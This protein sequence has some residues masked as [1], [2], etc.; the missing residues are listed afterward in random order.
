M[1]TEIN[2]LFQLAADY[3]QFTNEAIFLTGKAGT[4][5]TTFLKYI[6][7]NSGKQ[8][9]IVA[10]TGVAAINAGGT[11][12]HSF[13]QLPFTP[14]VPGPIKGNFNLNFD[15]QPQSQREAVIDK[16]HLLGRI[17]INREKRDIIRQLELLIIDEISMVRCDTLD[18]I[19]TVLRHIRGK[20]YD[21]FGGVQILLIGDLHQ[22]PPVIPNEE[23]AMLSQFYDSPY[24]FSSRVAQ[25]QPPVYIELEKIYRQSDA[26]FIDVLNKVRNHKM[27]DDAMNTLQTR[28][29]PNF[30]TSDNDGYIVLT[31]HNKKA[32]DI[33]QHGL[34]NLPN[35]QI[36]FKAFIEKD[37]S[38]KAFP[39]EE[40]LQLKVGAQVMFIKNDK[41]KVR[42]YFNGKIGIVQKIDEDIIYVQ[43]K[44]DVEPIKVTKEKWE[45][46]KY[47]LNQTNQQI[48]EEVIGSFTQFPLRLAWA[49]T[50]HKSQGL[51]FEKAVIDAGSA[52]APGQVYVALSRCTSLEGL[53]LQSLITNNSLFTDERILAFA[54]TK[55]NAAALQNNLLLSKQLY[56]EKIIAE[57]F[58]FDKAVS[59]IEDVLKLL[60]EHGGSFNED[61]LPWVNE[62]AKC[63]R[64]I[65]NVASRFQIQ[66]QQ[67][68]MGNNVLAINER[69][70]KAAA[71]F[72]EH[73][74]YLLQ[75]LPQS[76]AVTDSRNYAQEYYND[77]KALHAEIYTKFQLIDACKEGFNM[78]VYQQQKINLQV[79]D[80]NINT[81]AGAVYKKIDTPHPILYKQL[82]ELRDAICTTENSPIYYV[83]KSESLEEMAKYL[84]LDEK[85]LKQITGFGE[86]KIEKYGQQFLSIIQAYCADKN[87]QTLIHEKAPKKEKKEKQTDTDKLSSSV[88]TL[89]L[90]KQGLSISEIAA[91]RNLAVSTV[92]G[93]LAQLIIS[94]E[95]NVFTLM[96]KEK[97]MAVVE[98]INTLDSQFAG[99]LMTHL[100][101]NYSYTELRYGINYW[102]YLQTQKT[103]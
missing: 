40:N 86:A 7:D 62:I 32:A 18:A 11:T 74:H 31:T 27:D 36:T 9:A 76:P 98:A 23:W 35:R 50:I 21:A 47:T 100:G 34:Q 17:K 79:P 99:A 97:V 89:T 72:L 24:F 59:H 68:F 102:K 55:S 37:F 16:H 82:R 6:K 70:I 64:S 101:N 73:L 63:L 60:E 58:G 94:N 57:L 75:T 67:L 88:Q 14:F 52:F 30:T 3:I 90:H 12:I 71:Y 51:T 42:R 48:E 45:N 83:A 15:A 77:I 53:V 56:Q 10:P 26:V 4:G 84:P 95:V 33:N 43:C 25:Q 1:T 46:I 87:L 22:L 29:Q 49:I 44:G 28:Y 8:S 91:Q 69:V 66:L 38:D 92:E 96:P 85:D 19:D 20:Q 41:E 2:Q 103:V 61:T 54:K 81:Y 93:H 78:Q 65:K 80:I 39:A 13:F 5:K